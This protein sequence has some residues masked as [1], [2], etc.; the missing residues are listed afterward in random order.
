MQCPRCRAEVDPQAKFCP[1]CGA[2]LA[3][4]E[5]AGT[6]PGR[7]AG[8]AA[9]APRGDSIS[10]EEERDLWAGGYSPKAMVG[11][12]ALLAIVSVV[13]IVGAVLGGTVGTVGAGAPLVPIAVGLIVVLWL[14][15]ACVLLYRKWSVRYQVT[16]QRLIHRHGLVS[17]TTDRIELIDVDDITFTQGLVERMFGVGT[18]NIRSS[19]ATHPELQL[20][21]ID[22]VQRVADVIDDARRKERRRRG[23]HIETV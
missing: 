9:F 20:K 12:W 7:A 17:M 22:N 21:G 16:T 3:E 6:A 10:E 8:A 1:A 19:D 11:V 2:S 23:V 18:I 4:R 13:V 15:G 5:A 14:I